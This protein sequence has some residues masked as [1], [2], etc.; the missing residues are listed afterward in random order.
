MK[1]RKIWE[2]K[3]SAQP[4]TLDMYIYDYI[5]GDYYDWWSNET[6]ESE[7]SAEHFRSELAKYPDV[8]QINLYINS[9]GGY[10]YEAMAIR[11]QLKRH[12][13]KIVGCVDGFAC[14]AASFILT[15]CDVVRMYSNTMQM[16]HEMRVGAYGNSRELRKAA[17]DVDVVMTGN[18]QAYLEKSGGKITE[19]KLIEL[20]DKETWLT[21]QQCME[22]GFC[23]EIISEEVDLKAAKEMLE[24]VNRTFE[25]QLSYNKA[26]TAQIKE[27]RQSV[28]DP[29]PA[30]GQPPEPEQDPEPEPDP[31]PEQNKPQKLIAALFR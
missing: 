27:L 31:E 29:E 21:A 22:Y 7:T 15:A 4:D 16:I 11:N 13:A 25:Q 20:M 3:Q 1:R 26:L 5:E 23:D 30:P 14:S 2:F 12:P 17:D 19:E 9:Y 10:V 24:K 18:R 28:S 8:K 6:I